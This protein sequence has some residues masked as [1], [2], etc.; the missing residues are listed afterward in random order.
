MKLNSNIFKI[1]KSFNF[2]LMEIM[3]SVNKS[4]NL[5]KNLVSSEFSKNGYLVIENFIDQIVCNKIIEDIDYFITKYPEEIFNVN[6]KNSDFR[7]WGFENFSDEAKKYL[8]NKK[9]N[10]IIN[11]YDILFKNKKSFVLGAKL[12]A[13]D[14]RMGSGGGEWH[15]DRT[16]RK[17]KYCKALVY[18]NDVDENNGPFQYIKGSHKSS[19]LIRNFIKKNFGFDKKNFSD[20]EINNNFYNDIVTF[21]K[22][23]GT[24]IIFDGTGIHRGKPIEKNIRYALTNYYRNSDETFPYKMISQKN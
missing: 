8:M 3:Y 5:K 20:D 4:L 11:N 22:P 14:H 7:L 6:N 24:V 2:V 15:K 13:N 10:Q 23:K 1:I 16:N 12:I 18:L 21:K 17:Y 19:F 9:L